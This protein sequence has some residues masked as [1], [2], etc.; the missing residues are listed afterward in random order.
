MT[1][2][3][4]TDSSCDLPL[5]LIEQHHIAVV[6]LTVEIGGT[7]YRE[8]VDLTPQQFYAKMARSDKLPK[9]SQPT[10]AL[11][12][13][14]FRELGADGPVL[15]LTISSKLSGT[16][17][18]ACL[19]R[20]LAGVD[21]TVFDTLAGSLGQGLQVL[22]A[23]ELAE[24]GASVADTVEALTTYRREMTTLILLNTLEN[25]VKGGRL[26]RFQ[27]SLS[28]MLDIRVLLRDDDGA[29]VPLERVHGRRRLLEHAVAKVV[30][31]RPDL[32]DRDV[33]ITHF[34][35][36]GDADWIAREI[37]QSCHPRGVIINEMGSTMATYAGEEGMIVA[38]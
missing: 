35:N 12:A 14:T 30:A 10:P 23:C 37:T 20:D 4:V 7:V 33:G 34:N 16:Y 8:D 9:T 26:S 19:G 13:D 22:R 18:S 32:S 27:G 5:D 38:F 1:L 11:F 6:P 2:H 29:V 3:V 28:K 36:P 31:T 17:E 24:A 25:I 21:A 15:C